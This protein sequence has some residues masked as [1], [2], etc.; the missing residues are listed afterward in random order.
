MCT[1]IVARIDLLLIQIAVRDRTANMPSCYMSVEI[2]S[3][4]HNE[5]HST[6]YCG[7]SLV[8]TNSK[9]RDKG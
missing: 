1:I 2:L 6:V 5:Y 7:L 9:K 4:A 3:Y 8:V